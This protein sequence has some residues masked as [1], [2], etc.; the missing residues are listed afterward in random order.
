MPLSVEKLFSRTVDSSFEIDGDIV[1]LKWAPARYT[2]EMDDLAERMRE[3]AEDGDAK[4]AELRAADDKDGADALIRQRDRADAA[5]TRTFVATMLVDWD[6]MLGTTTHPHDEAGLL[7]LPDWFVRTVF[8]A[9]SEENQVD[10]TSPAPSDEPSEPKARPAP[11]PR[12]S[13]SSGARK[14]SGSRRGK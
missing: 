2:G 13:R 11:S 6:V 5:A 4:L 3:E 14:S 9:L 8:L 7:K 1:H 12:G 10:P